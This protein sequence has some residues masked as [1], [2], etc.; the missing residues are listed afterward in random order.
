VPA[1]TASARKPRRLTVCVLVIAVFSQKR[2][3]RCGSDH[4]ALH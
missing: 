4:A 2:N 3:G 1:A